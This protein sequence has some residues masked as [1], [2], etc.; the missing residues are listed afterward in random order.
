MKSPVILGANAAITR[1]SPFVQVAWEG[2]RPSIFGLIPPR[3]HTL[4]AV[5]LV[6]SAL[7]AGDKNEFNSWQNAHANNRQ[8]PEVNFLKWM[9][10][11]PVTQ[12]LLPYKTESYDLHQVPLTERFWN[13][14]YL[15]FAHVPPTEIF[16]FPKKYQPPESVH[17]FYFHVSGNYFVLGFASDKIR[18]TYLADFEAKILPADA[19]RDTL[20]FG[21]NFFAG[22]WRSAGHLVVEGQ[23]LSLALFTPSA[24]KALK[25]TQMYQTA[26]SDFFSAPGITSETTPN[27]TTYFFNASKDFLGLQN[28]NGNFRVTR[29]LKPAEAYN[30]ASHAAILQRQLDPYGLGIV[31][32]SAWDQF[33]IGDRLVTKIID[34]FGFCRGAASMDAPL[35]PIE[36]ILATTYRRLTGIAKKATTVAE[37]SPLHMGIAKTSL[38]LG[39]W[40]T[41]S[42]MAGRHKYLRFLWLCGTKGDTGLI[43]SDGQLLHSQIA[44]LAFDENLFTSGFRV[45]GNGLMD[46]LRGGTLE[47]K[48]DNE[49]RAAAI[50][51]FDDGVLFPD[52][53]T[54]RSEGVRIR[55]SPT[56]R[57]KFLNQI[58]P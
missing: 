24:F 36:E 19:P 42:E 7:S 16:G 58:T 6:L 37:T 47:L 20:S 51:L 35:P 57:D 46:I 18:E 5:P 8:D 1:E 38:G 40:M 30:T 13:V 44:R 39:S 45:P 23:R 50:R 41:N 31:S 43:V 27:G 15:G 14:P 48:Y 4:D 55:M 34:G 2:T 54:N 25:K 56:E 17:H 10:T 52:P 28:A 21:G 9:A 53:G 22:G 32:D 11:R 26:P 33:V 3:E 12:P 49:G 29:A